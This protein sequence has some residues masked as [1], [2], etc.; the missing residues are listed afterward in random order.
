VAHCVKTD[1]DW[2]AAFATAPIATHFQT[3]GQLTTHP[4][5]P[6]LIRR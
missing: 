6:I 3:T 4:S 2:E 1:V 5:F